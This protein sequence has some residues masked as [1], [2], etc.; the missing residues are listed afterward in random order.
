MEQWTSNLP[1]AS[2]LASCLR[3]AATL[4]D[5]AALT[6]EQIDAICKLFS[7]NLKETLQ[8][9][10]SLLKTALSNERS[11]QSN[12]KFGTYEGNFGRISN[13][14]TQLYE[15]I[16]NPNPHW[17]QAMRLTA[18]RCLLFCGWVRWPGCRRPRPG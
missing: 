11:R 6:S 16:G 12:S 17:E 1:L 8:T 4:E 3:P 10:C 9:N 15:D 5:V 2:T 13:F 18:S 14:H 7:R